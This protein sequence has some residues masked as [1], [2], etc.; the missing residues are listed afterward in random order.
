MFFKRTGRGGDNKKS[1]L[2]QLI[3]Q[4]TGLT[5]TSLSFEQRDGGGVARKKERQ[6][7]KETRHV[8]GDL[9]DIC[10]SHKTPVAVTTP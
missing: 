7:Q 8:T 2:I 5:T 6:E 3:T 4:R 1:L 9:G 10:G